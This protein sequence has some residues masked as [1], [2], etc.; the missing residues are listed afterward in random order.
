MA[1]GPGTAGATGPPQVS[2]TWVTEVTASGATLRAEINPAEA[3]TRYR[4]EY[5][6]EAAYE[7]NLA[8]SREG[9]FG[10]L[11]VP[12]ASEPVVGSG[13]TNQQVNQHIGGLTPST[14]YRYRVRATST[15]GT[16]FGPEHTFTTQGSELT[17]SLPDG[18]GWEMVSP[19]D[20]NG[21]AI[22]SVGST[23]PRVFQAAAD[24]QS[25]TYSSIY[26][27][28]DPEGAPAPSQYLSKRGGLGWTTDD[29]TIPLLSGSYG[30]EPQA[31][32]YQLFT[33]DLS[34][35]IV[36]NGKRCRGEE[37]QCPVANPPL[38]G[39]GAPAGYMNYYRRDADGQ[40]AALLTQSDVADLEIAPQ[41]FEAAMVASSADLGHVVLSSCTALTPEATEFAGGP[42]SCDSTKPNLYEFSS[43]GLEL[44]NVLPGQSQ[45]T[46][47]AE[48]A[49]QGR[50]VSVGGSV[51]WVD[52]ES[53]NLYLHRPGQGSVQ[54]D[55]TAGGGGRFQ[56]ASGD[57]AI[58]YFT[59][60]AHLYRYT[61]ATETATDLTPG[62][63]VQGV[64]GAS[65]DGSYLYY[66]S[67]AGLR[68]WHNGATVTVAASAD[69]S[70]YPPST[71]TARVSPDGTH[72]AFLSSASLTGYDNAGSSEV[73]L[74]G[75]PPGGAVA[76][77]TCVSCNPTG[78]RPRGP[79]TI[80]G[81]VA[82]GKGQDAID[83][84][85]P[86]ALSADG[87]RVFFD[88]ADA[89]VVQDTNERPD[90]YEREASGA[91]TCVATNSC[92][93]LISSGRSGEGA[94]FVDASAN[95][96]DVFFLTDGSLVSGD[97]GSVDLYDAREGGG[98]PP[99]PSTPTTC[100]GDAC[101]ALPPSPEDPTP[102]TLVA[103]PGNPVKHVAKKK[104]KPKKKKHKKHSK[105]GHG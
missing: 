19:V 90:V 95:G 73:F 20:K 31:T 99:T 78:E 14:S 5:L 43:G 86:R 23:S 49:A 7:A 29:L 67:I 70:N 93:S 35:G 46:P 30:D 12:L 102:G 15:Q 50:A 80:P 10:A 104:A 9:F 98:F 38:P 13:N 16:V 91:G 6:S 69:A 26:S 101:Q 4:F 64:L 42:G 2:A 57:G 71:G 37:D 60:A 87:S 77:L 53:G 17:F 54:V 45:G 97:P 55:S 103:N 66:Q 56:T 40:F 92:I 24:G 82:N 59:K 63:E 41:N 89:L 85:K 51:Y 36:L 18:R 79:S 28:G 22:E 1:L 33:S 88:S 44:V 3:S 105:G 32:P 83:V 11:R 65:D 8:A 74:Y 81:A 48:V 68:L 52:T 94:S 61:L 72:L 58:A 27:F 100:E 21:G 47:G 25:V 76:T 96:S 84:Y 75:P 34:Q 39:S 62:G